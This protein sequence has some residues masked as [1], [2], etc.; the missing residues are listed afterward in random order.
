MFDHFV[1]IPVNRTRVAAG[2]FACTSACTSI[3]A[4]VQV[5]PLSESVQL[6]V[7]EEFAAIGGISQDIGVRLKSTM[8][9]GTSYEHD[10]QD[11]QRVE[12]PR[13]V[14]EQQGM[15]LSS[16]EYWSLQREAKEHYTNIPRV[17]HFHDHSTRS[18]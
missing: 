14:K 18:P 16:K 12:P 11:R 5:F 9:N 6:L 7:M 4:A 2:V 8:L 10:A 1:Y 15:V 17:V 13:A 3:V